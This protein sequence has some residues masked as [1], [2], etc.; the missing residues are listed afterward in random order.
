MSMHTGE[1]LYRCAECEKSFSQAC[2][3]RTHLVNHTGEKLYVYAQCSLELTKVSI[4]INS[5]TLLYPVS[6]LIGSIQRANG[7]YKD[8]RVGQLTSR[9]LKW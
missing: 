3:L 2:H 9:G 7:K 4:S 6:L 8:H 5:S 1:K